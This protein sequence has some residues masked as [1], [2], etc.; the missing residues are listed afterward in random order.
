MVTFSEPLIGP[1]VDG[2]N[3]TG[4]DSVWPELSLAGNGGDVAPALKSAGVAPTAVTVSPA[5]AVSVAVFTALWPTVV[6]PH[7]RALPVIGVLTGEPKPRT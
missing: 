1:E 5:V 3:V 4:T 2:L 6:G 7:V